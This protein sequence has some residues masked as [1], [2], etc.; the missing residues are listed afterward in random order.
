[1]Y[2]TCI[3]LSLGCSVCEMIRNF[4]D[5]LSL[6]CFG[7]AYDLKFLVYTAF[8]GILLLESA[9]TARMCWGAGR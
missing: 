9:D 2:G 6:Y 3:S 1:M 7:C 4:Y 5:L 8:S